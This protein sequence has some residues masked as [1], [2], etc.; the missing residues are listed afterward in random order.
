MQLPRF[1]RVIVPDSAGRIVSVWH[2]DARRAGWNY[3]GGKVEPGEDP[4]EA[5]R[6]EVWEE[7]GLKVAG[8]RL[9]YEGEYFFEDDGLCYGY[10]YTADP[11]DRPPT[12]REPRK[13]AKVE[14]LS[15]DEI[16]LHAELP[17]V[18]EMLDLHLTQAGAKNMNGFIPRNH[19]SLTIV[20]DWQEFV[21]WVKDAGYDESYLDIN[22]SKC[23]ALQRTFLEEASADNAA[24]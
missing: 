4:K 23:L 16:A 9:I 11:V 19:A 6:R 10:I 5:A 14:V 1:V 24:A 20:P 13:L 2:S 22:D 8:L 17:F 7:V 18:V 3:P 12:N 21:A 15:R